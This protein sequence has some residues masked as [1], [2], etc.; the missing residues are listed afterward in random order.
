MIDSSSKP[1][2]TKLRLLY[3]IWAVVGM[4]GILYVPSQIFMEGDAS[5]TAQ[6]LIANELLFRTGI[7]SRLITQ[8]MFIVIVWYLY[9]LFKS[10]SQD[11][12]LMMVILALV[13]IP[14]AMYNEMNAFSAISSIDQPIQLMKWLSLHSQG[15]NMAS[16]FWGL[17]LFPLGYLV[18]H[19]KVFPS[20]LGISVYVG[21]VGYLV[22]AMGR[23]VN[24]DLEV[25]FSI[26]EVMTLG[27]II[28][29]LWLIIRGAKFQKS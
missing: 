3:P 1:I 22:G 21:G 12:G 9:K 20:W 2:V 28:W 16:I 8:L 18:Y 25:L 15:I 24:P 13:S 4:F 5:A 26:T 7:V 27:E 19:S 29:L 23:I 10:I 6:N 14:I 17:W 11:A